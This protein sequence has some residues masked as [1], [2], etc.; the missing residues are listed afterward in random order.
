MPPTVTQLDGAEPGP[1]K[2]TPPDFRPRVLLSLLAGGAG[3]VP[4]ASFRVLFLPLSVSNTLAQ[5]NELPCPVT[6]N[7][8]TP[9]RPLHPAS[10]VCSMQGNQARLWPLVKAHLVPGKIPLQLSLP[11]P[12][13][14]D[15]H[16][17]SLAKQFVGREER[18]LLLPTALAS[19]DEKGPKV[20]RG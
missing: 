7:T 6:M 8:R 16:R 1:D 18:L 13:L 5:T 4:L 2:P 11:Y 17:G 20:G 15:R 10:L 12:S 14:G 3:P 9:R 19:W